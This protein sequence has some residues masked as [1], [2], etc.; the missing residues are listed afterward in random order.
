MAV[1]DASAMQLV[2]SVVEML[3]TERELT[4]SDLKS[5]AESKAT[6]AAF[7]A[8]SEKLGQSPD[9]LEQILKGKITKDD[10][11]IKAMYRRRANE[12][13]ERRRRQQRQS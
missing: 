1:Y 2:L 4:A 5:E 13:R 6:L 11:R 8:V 12:L 9:F 3:S 10:H 7:R